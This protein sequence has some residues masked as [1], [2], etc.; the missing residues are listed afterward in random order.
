MP[1]MLELFCGRNKSVS[2]VFADA[3]WE[4]TTLDIDAKAEP[5]ILSCIMQWD[6]LQLPI[7]HFDYIHASPPCEEL[8]SAKMGERDLATADALITRTLFILARFQPKF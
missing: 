3:G 4:T 6:F 1:R 7:C 2:K 8:S 5:D